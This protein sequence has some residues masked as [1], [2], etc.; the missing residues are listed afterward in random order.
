M[1]VNGLKGGLQDEE[2]VQDLKAHIFWAGP[3][4]WEAIKFR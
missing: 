4:K 3:A 1:S 2:K